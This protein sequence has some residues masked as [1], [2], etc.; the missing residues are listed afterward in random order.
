MSPSNPYINARREWDERYG[1]SL[2]R[3]RNW[4]IAAIIAMGVAGVA[5]AGAAYIGAQSKVEPFVVAIDSLGN[6]IAMARPSS[7]GDVSVRIIQAQVANL[8]WNARTILSDQAAQKVLL[9]RV[10]AFLSTDSSAY[11]NDYYKTHSPFSGDGSTVNVEINSVLP[12]SRDSYQVNWT[13]SRFQSSQPM[14]SSHWKASVTIGIDKKLADKPRMS[15]DNPLG[16]YIKSITWTQVL[17][18]Q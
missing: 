8:I 3:A 13:E 12:I 6:P 10:Y 18:N 2:S 15:I 11:L 16:I 9:A 4:R 1:D 14:G 17:G 5:V 7:A